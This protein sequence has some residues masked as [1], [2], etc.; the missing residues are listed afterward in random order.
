[1]VLSVMSCTVVA[2]G[3]V[4]MPVTTLAA[5]VLVPLTLRFVKVL[6]VSVSEV[7]LLF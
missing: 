3:N 6:L 5:E 7:G 4:R 1:M 2:S